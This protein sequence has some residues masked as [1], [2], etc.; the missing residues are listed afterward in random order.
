M[1]K[2][3]VFTAFVALLL[4]PSLTFGTQPAALKIFS[5][6]PA[7]RKW[8]NRYPVGNGFMGAMLDGGIRLSKIQF[9]ADSLWTGD[10][11]LDGTTKDSQADQNYRAMGAYQNFGELSFLFDSLGE[12][13]EYRRELDLSRAIY[14][15]SI[16]QGGVHIIRQAFASVADRV[17]VYRI[18][19][20]S[21]INGRMRLKGTHRES[22][23]AKDRMISFS[24]KLENGLSY[25]AKALLLPVDGGEV[26]AQ[27]SELHFISCREL[28]ALLIPETDYDMFRANFR[29]RAKLSAVDSRLS[30]AAAKGYEALERDH[31]AA[32]SRYFN[33]L[34][35]NLSG[36]DPTLRAMTIPQRIARCREGNRDPELAVLLYQF[37]RYLLISSSWRGSLPANLQGVWNDSNR[38]AWSCDYHTNINLQMNYWGA[39][40]ANLSEMH[41]TLFDWMVAMLPNVRAETAKAFPGSRGYSYRTSANIFGGMG[42]RWNLPGAAWLAHHAYDH[43]T[44]TKDKAFLRKVGLPI[45]KGAA[46]FCLSHLKT[47]PDGTIVVPNGWSPEHGPREDGVTHDQQIFSQI[48]ADVLGIREAIGDCGDPEFFNEVARVK[49]RL[50]GNK[51]GSWGQLQEWEKDRDRKGNQHRHTSHLFAV[52]PGIEITPEKTPELAKAAGVALDGR[53]LTGDAHRSWT[54]PWRAALWARLHDGKR[55]GEMVDSLLRYNTLPNLFTTHPPF[56]ID[57]NLGIVGAVSEALIQSHTGTIVLLPVVMPGWE[58]GSVRGLRARGDVTVDFDWKGGR[59]TRYTLASGRNQSVKVKVNGKERGVALKAGAPLSCTL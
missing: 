23:A 36:C 46:E 26:K 58:S 11:N 55:A 10:E 6:R 41:K 52:Y 17:I 4:L 37:G 54:W 24:G 30:V 51:I 57:G 8:A 34:S 19:S 48:F 7:Q 42:W 3:T 18:K 47:R 16:R 38:P 50:L 53:A 35:L 44:F 9:N 49:G 27:N 22:S 14:T 56:Q 25:T 20:S 32:Y 28:L 13:G 29:N 5:D 43:Y 39:D 45:I 21:P 40:V 15:D 59:V 31:V 2:I 33:R 12:G 1:K